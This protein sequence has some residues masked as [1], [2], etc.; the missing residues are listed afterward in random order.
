M[1]IVLADQTGKIALRVK[2]AKKTA[3]LNTRN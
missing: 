3:Y 1:Y 2:T